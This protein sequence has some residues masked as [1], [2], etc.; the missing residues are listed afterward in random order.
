MSN[1][2]EELYEHEPIDDALDVDWRMARLDRRTLRVARKLDHVEEEFDRAQRELSDKQ[3]SQLS[4]EEFFQALVRGA[5]VGVPATFALVMAIAVTAGFVPITAM[6][7]AIWPA[8]VAGPYMGGLGTLTYACERAE[9]PDHR[10]HW[11]HRHA[12]DTRMRTA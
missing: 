3:A 9:S 8:I 11:F 7:V 6:F 10:V 2:A 5:V 1:E 12:R 4:D